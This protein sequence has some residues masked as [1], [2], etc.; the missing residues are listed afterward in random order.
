MG[1]LQVLCQSKGEIGTGLSG[2]KIVMFRRVVFLM[3][4]PHDGA[5]GAKDG[6]MYMNFGGGH[7]IIEQII[8]NIQ[9][10]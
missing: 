5:G 6:V 7:S 9:I 1:S 4:W 2:K 3:N 8:E 10:S